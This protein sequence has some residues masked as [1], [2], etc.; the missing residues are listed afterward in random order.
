MSH[1][2]GEGPLGA[3]RALRAR[4]LEL[5]EAVEGGRADATALRRIAER[6]SLAVDELVE[7]TDPAGVDP[8]ELEELARLQALALEAV[9]ARRAGVDGLL[10]R[11]RHTRRSFRERFG[12]SAGGDVCDVTG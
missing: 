1:A 12:R 3:A 5:L 10:E 2:G 7:G 6:W 9:R 11:V 8:R 4:T